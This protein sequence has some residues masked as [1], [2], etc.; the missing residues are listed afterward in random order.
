VFIELLE[1]DGA[2]GIEPNTVKKYSG[3]KPHAKEIDTH[4]SNG[5]STVFQY[6]ATP[7]HLLIMLLLK[8]H[9][10]SNHG[11]SL[12]Q[13]TCHEQKPKNRNLRVTVDQEPAQF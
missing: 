10:F 5:E 4:N 2:G 13:R 11:L 6:A 8:H 3:E 12:E 7:L 9:D 1:K